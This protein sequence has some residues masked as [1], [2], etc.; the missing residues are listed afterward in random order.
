[1]GLSDLPAELVYHI[2][3][4]L[5]LDSDLNSLVRTST[6]FYNV[7]NNELYRQTV[8]CSPGKAL[9]WV[10]SNGEESAARKLLE[11]GTSPYG[12]DLKHPPM[13]L[14]I[15]R[16]HDT[17]VQLLLE[18]ELK[19][20]S[21]CPLIPG[22]VTDLKTYWKRFS[23]IRWAI[24]NSRDNLI[25][26]FFGYGA[27]KYWD[28]G[29]VC[30]AIQ[31]AIYS[32]NPSAVQVLLD[33]F[34]QAPKEEHHFRVG[35]LLHEALLYINPEIVRCLVRFGADVNFVIQNTCPLK[36]AAKL[37]RN[38]KNSVCLPGVLDPQR[39]QEIIDFLLEEGAYPAHMSNNKE[40]GLWKLRWAAER[41]DY[42]GVG[43][44]LSQIDTESVIQSGGESRAVLLLTAAAC[45]LNNLAR[46]VLDNGGDADA[47]CHP[48]LGY[49][50][51]R[52]PLAWAA[53]R[54][55]AEVATILLNYGA[56]PNP[57]EPPEFYNGD[58]DYVWSELPPLTEACYYGHIELVNLL[59]DHGA[60]M[61]TETSPSE[62]EEEDTALDFAVNYPE[63]VNL[64]L[65]RGADAKGHVVMKALHSGNTETVRILLDHGACITAE[66]Q[67]FFMS[68]IPEDKRLE[69]LALLSEYGIQPRT[70]HPS[71]VITW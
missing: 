23:G 43:R 56:D 11:A 66:Q 54:G 49:T 71:E 67:S 16:G 22:Q 62:L 46:Q 7:L 63:I 55:H 68:I 36:L 28:I 51:P 31:Q 1:M 15:I 38:E 25:P 60:N 3:S 57:I 32:R 53:R 18:W 47:P 17:M 10:A 64:L 5:T 41:N 24:E 61:F 4:Y 37:I 30:E 35:T 8:S 14:A 13:E 34:P 27:A 48:G 58:T 52:T 50:S 39:A 9:D 2:S 6:G 21:K 44:H 69:M 29:K 40:F 59:L 45:G 65:S 12:E 19:D 42:A 70:N 33:H 20:V 26:M